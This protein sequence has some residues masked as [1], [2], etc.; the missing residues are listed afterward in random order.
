M[1][2]LEDAEVLAERVVR[3]A[4][5]MEVNNKYLDYKVFT[6]VCRRLIVEQMDVEDIEKLLEEQV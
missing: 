3:F 1:I 4:N 2:S 5:W 6:L